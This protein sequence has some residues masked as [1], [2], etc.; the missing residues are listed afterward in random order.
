MSNPY[1]FRSLEEAQSRIDEYIQI[2][3]QSRPQ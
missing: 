1:D 3:N 2:Y